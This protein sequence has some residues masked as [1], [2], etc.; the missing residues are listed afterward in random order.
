LPC[1]AHDGLLP[2]HLVFLSDRLWMRPNALIERVHNVGTDK[3]AMR[4]ALIR[5]WLEIT[6]SAV[7]D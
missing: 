7:C 6:C 2:E 4:D 5:G 3:L 1:R